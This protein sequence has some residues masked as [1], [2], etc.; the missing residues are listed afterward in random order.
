M[1]CP[2]LED[3]FAEQPVKQYVQVG[4]YSELVCGAPMGVPAPTVSTMGLH[5]TICLIWLI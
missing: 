5:P 3:R 1:S 2:D 4:V